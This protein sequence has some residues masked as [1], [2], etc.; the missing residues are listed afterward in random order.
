MTMS[1]TKIPEIY[2][3]EYLI[4]EDEMSENG[5]QYQLVSY[6]VQVLLWYYHQA[7][8]YVIGNLMLIHP[9]IENSRHSIT[10][11]LSVFKGIE[12][13]QQR[14]KN[15]PS[16]RIDKNHP[17]PPVVFEISSD[18][19]WKYDIGMGEQQKPKI[20]GRIGVKEYYAYDPFQER[21]WQ[22]EKRKLLGW[23]YDE[24]G[25]L[26]EIMPDERGWLWSDQ[27]DSW[28]GADGEYLRVYERG[29]A[30]R[31]TAA[32]AGDEARLVAE[33]ETRKEAQAR[34]AAEARIAEL[35]ELLRH[36]KGEN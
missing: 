25:E 27:L 7:N 24:K 2:S 29:G 20:Y 30:K 21:V 31:L 34:R 14:R 33:S 17:A 15:M 23:R 4:E 19:T 8:W 16:W 18:A 28:L 1:K 12:I 3:E 32:E 22:D 5:V 11:D 9:A 10:P 13:S 26:I 36:Q 6:L 35:E